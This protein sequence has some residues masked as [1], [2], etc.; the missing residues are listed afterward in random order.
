MIEATQLEAQSTQTINVTF[1]KPFR[2]KPFISLSLCTNNANFRFGMISV[3]VIRTSISTTG[4]SAQVHN[5]SSMSSMQAPSIAW[6]A[7]EFGEP[8]IYD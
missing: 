3:S 1:D 4:F 6:R 8:E 2:Q 7:E 5:A